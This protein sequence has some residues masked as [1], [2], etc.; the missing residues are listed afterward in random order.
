LNRWPT[1]RLA[2]NPDVSVLLLEAGGDDNIPEI[3]DAA[4]W[5]MN[6]GT[7]RQWNFQAQSNPRLN[8]RVL[9]LNMGRVLG[10]G[11]SVNALIWARGHKNDWDFFAA[12]ANSKAW[13]YESVLAIYR[14][15]EDWHGVPDPKRRGKAGLLFVQPPPDPNPIASAMLDGAGLF[16]IQRFDDA[17]GCMM[18]GEGGAALTNLL[19]RDG[20]RLSL[21]RT[22]VYPL[23]DRPNLTV[24][25][26]ALI[27]RQAGGRGG[28][29]LWR[30]GPSYSC[31][32]RNDPVTRSDQHPQAAHA[33]GRGGRS[34]T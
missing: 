11:S 32:C 24:L 13:N 30:R 19:V 10:G 34:R 28:D 16:G 21:F 9:P 17:N 7:E 18:E 1:R 6:L 14:R 25:S 4:K 27:R 8:G 15:I 20:R 2:E 31:L 33:I 3:M 23:M 12:E 29:L 5:P 26:S 22:Y